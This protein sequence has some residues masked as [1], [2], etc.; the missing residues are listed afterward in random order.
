MYAYSMCVYDCVVFQ[1]QVQLEK[2]PYLSPS[3][4][5]ERQWDDG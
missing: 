1:K 3:V 4:L 2:P 5:A